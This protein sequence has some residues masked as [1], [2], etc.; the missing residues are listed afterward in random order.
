[1]T[2]TGSWDTHEDLQIT[3][4]H[5]LTRDLINPLDH[6][7]EAVQRKQRMQVK[8]DQRL[9]LIN[10]SYDEH[11]CQHFATHPSTWK[12]TLADWLI[13]SAADTLVIKV[14]DRERVTADDPTNAQMITIP[15]GIEDHSVKIQL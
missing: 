6:T 2:C 15:V 11:Y 4:E 13:G 12:L 9:I 8:A 14:D 5:F 1:L 7:N 3:R 10:T